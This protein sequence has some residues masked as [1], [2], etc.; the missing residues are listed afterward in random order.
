MLLQLHRAHEK[1]LNVVHLTACWNSLCRLA[2]EG[3]ATRNAK[4]VEEATTL[5]VQ[6]TVRRAV[7]GLLDVRALANVAHAAASINLKSSLELASRAWACGMSDRAGAELFLVLAMAAE[8]RVGQFS[9]QNLANAAW[10]FATS[11]RVDAQLF[12]ALAES[13]DGRVGAFKS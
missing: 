7:A 2:R 4:A 13:A 6:L 11:G 5:L 10:A 12:A 3:P 1:D 9:A 8:R